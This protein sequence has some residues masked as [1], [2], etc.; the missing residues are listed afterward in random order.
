MQCEVRSP[1][2]PHIGGSEIALDDPLVEA[3]AHVH[4]TGWRQAYGDLIPKHFY[5][6][7]ARAERAHMWRSTLMHDHASD[8]VR[9]AT[10]TDRT[11]GQSDRTFAGVVI[12]FSIHG[13]ARDADRTGTEL[14]ALYVLQEHYGSGAGQGLLDSAIGDSPACLW[15]AAENPRAIRFYEKNGFRSDGMRRTDADVEGLEEI[16]MVRE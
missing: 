13:P 10:R 9:I 11:I 4:V 2:P 1:R 16:R 12:G 6:E 7:A 5:D 3:L 14:Y 15:V 8:R